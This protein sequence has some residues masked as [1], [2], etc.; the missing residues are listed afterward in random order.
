MIPAPTNATFTRSGQVVTFRC[1]SVTGKLFTKTYREGKPPL[2]T[3]TSGPTGDFYMI[4]LDG[5][6]TRIML[7]NQVGVEYSAE[8]LAWEGSAGI[9]DGPKPVATDMAVTPAKLAMA[10]IHI[11]NGL[12]I[13]K[14]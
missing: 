12:L 10:I 2:T 11:Q 9:T 13:L 4:P 14:S 7:M 5:L 8:V 3:A 6:Q 1:S